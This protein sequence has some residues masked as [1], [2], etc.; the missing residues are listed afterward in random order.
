MFSLMKPA[1][2]VPI[3]TPS[4]SPT[5]S[6]GS[7][8]RTTTRFRYGTFSAQI[9]C[10]GGNTSGLNF[11]LYLSSLEGD[12]SQDEIDFEFLGKDRT[13]VQTNFYNAGTGNREKI[14]HLG[15]DCSDKFHLYVIN[16]G[17]DSIEWLIDG[18]II[19]T[20]ERKEGLGF[21]HRPMFLYASIWDASYIAKGSWTGTYV[22]CDAPY[23][24]LYKEIH[25]PAGT[26][27]VEDI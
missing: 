12:K 18:K 4:H 7:R 9:R 14:H 3:L 20:E 22:G 11:N 5:I 17:P 23:H 26:V 13:I 2:T 15:F 21:P 19:R 10:P 25:V 8:W 24:C 1:L 16:W 27:V 6:A